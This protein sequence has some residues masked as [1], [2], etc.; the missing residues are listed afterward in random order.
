MDGGANSGSNNCSKANSCTFLP[1][2]A[3][4]K[5]FNEVF[6]R[7]ALRAIML[8][9]Y[10]DIVWGDGTEIS[11][12]RADFLNLHRNEIIKEFADLTVQL[13]TDYAGLGKTFILSNWEGDSQV[14]CASAWGYAQDL[15]NRIKC[16]E[17]YRT[18]HLKLTKSVD[19]AFK[20]LK[21]WFELRQ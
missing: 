3:R 15:R 17:A 4:L 16:D 11:F 18:G 21:L 5:D 10:D 9:T 2:L 1:W 6:H 12:L 14:Y 7:Q 8:A 20:G 13:M 19:D